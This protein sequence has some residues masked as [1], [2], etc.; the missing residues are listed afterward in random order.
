[1][2]KLIE[3]MNYRYNNPTVSLSIDE[4]VVRKFLE[5]YRERHVREQFALWASMSKENVDHKLENMVNSKENEL[6]NSKTK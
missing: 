4:K 3:E 1:M 5:Q 6:E 2:K